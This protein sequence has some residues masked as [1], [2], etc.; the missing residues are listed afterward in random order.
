MY[1]MVLIQFEF[2]GDGLKPV[3]F[4]PVPVPELSTIFIATS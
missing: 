1:I 3:F 2:K 4:D